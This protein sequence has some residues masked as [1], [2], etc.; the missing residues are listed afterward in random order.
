MPWTAQR[1]SVPARMTKSCVVAAASER[2]NLPP[3][4]RSISQGRR[5]IIQAETIMPTQK[6][7]ETARETEAEKSWARFCWKR[8][9]KK[10]SEAAPAAAPMTLKGA[11]NRLL[12]LVIRVM[13]PTWAEAKN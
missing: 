3:R 10:G 9:A 1:A 12:A 5:A 13:P 2:W 4:K 8:E 6:R 11:L 7:R